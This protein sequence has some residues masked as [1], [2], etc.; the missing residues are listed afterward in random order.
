MGAGFEACF[1][2]GFLFPFCVTG[3]SAASSLEVLSFTDFSSKDDTDVLLPRLLLATFEDSS[4]LESDFKA[5]TAAYI[6][7]AVYLFD[8]DTKMNC[9]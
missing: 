8:K 2:P 3:G 1:V 7:Y 4:I 9:P 5:S 6:S